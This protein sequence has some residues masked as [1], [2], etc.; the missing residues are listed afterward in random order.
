M[1]DTPLRPGELPTELG[2]KRPR[3]PF[4]ERD[5]EGYMAPEPADVYARVAPV[6]F[7]ASTKSGEPQAHQ[8]E[9]EEL[10]TTNAHEDGGL[11]TNPRE[12]YPVG[13]GPKNA[14]KIKGVSE[15]I[16]GRDGAV[17]P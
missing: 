13:N 17:R 11:P 4:E 8:P 14:G 10:P 5:A 1:A 6:Q 16:G 15:K 7:S 12:P 2:D 3:L 9:P